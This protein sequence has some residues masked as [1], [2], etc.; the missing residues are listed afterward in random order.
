DVYK[1]QV[2]LLAKRG[3]TTPDAVRALAAAARV[4][5]G[6]VSFAGLKDRHAETS[7]YVA[8]EG[9]PDRDL[10]GPGWTARFAGFRSAPLSGADILA[11]RFRMVVQ[12]LSRESLRSLEDR[13]RALDRFGLVNYFGDQRFGSARH[14]RGFAAAEF[15]RGRAEEGLRLAMAVAARKDSAADKRFRRTVAEYWGRW[16]ECLKHLPPHPDRRAVEFLASPGRERDFAGAFAR[17][18]YDF[19]RF[20]VL[21]YQSFL[22]NETARGI[23]ESA[24]PG[25]ALL[26][27]DGAAGRMVFP[28]PDAPAPAFPGESVAESG[29]PDPANDVSTSGN[30][31]RGLTGPGSRG[32]RKGG[33]EYS[34]PDSSASCG[35]GI[36]YGGAAAS[37]GDPSGPLLATVS[38]PL[39]SRNADLSGPIG[40]M[41]ASVLA[42]EGVTPK[43][44][45]IGRLRRP[46]FAPGFRPL[47]VPVAGFRMS[48][49]APDPR[50]RSRF[51]VE[52]QFELPP[53]SYATVLLRMLVQARPYIGGGQPSRAGR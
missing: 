24:F 39:L 42:R 30:P 3:V 40:G 22:W 48:E 47:A 13:R 36:P 1:R 19:Q 27:A 23:I 25:D 53:G 32:V 10:A 52:L 37:G 34:G 26:Y 9:G 49:P 50:D 51:Q 21:A 11:N 18:P 41:A 5:P 31:G 35:R 20:C 12:D 29:C 4:H 14:G 8:V 33:R 28:A 6:R 43:D 38:V 17:L 46:F 45:R 7:Q 44:L 16:E 15:A 2:Y